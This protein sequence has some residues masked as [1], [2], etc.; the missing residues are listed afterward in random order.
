MSFFFFKSNKI[1]MALCSIGKK[2]NLYV[3]EFIYYY[4]KLG[5]NKIFIY[6]DNDVNTEKIKDIISFDK[7]IKVYENIKDKIKNQGDAYTDCYKNNKNKFDWFLMFD[8]DE[9]LVIVNNTLKEYL[10][11][12]IF[13]KCDFIKI[14]WVIPSDNNLLHYDNRTY[15]KDLKAHINLQV[16]LSQ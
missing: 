5:V 11:D 10:S 13:N 15:L 2:E 16:I 9:Y 1:K 4:K 6:D 3:K 12:K 14:N 8:F 7:S